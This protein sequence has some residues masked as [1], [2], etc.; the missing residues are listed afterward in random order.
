MRLLAQF[1]PTWEI[2]YDDLAEVQAVGKT[3]LFSTGVRFR[4]AS[5]N[6]WIVF[7]TFNRPKVLQ[8]ISN[9]GVQVNSLPI[10]VR[11]TDPGR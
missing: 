7:W 10:R 9:H 5:T 6:E 4:A 1:V 8:A 2:R 3:P 11:Y